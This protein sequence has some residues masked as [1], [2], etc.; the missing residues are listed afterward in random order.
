[1][2]R[3]S[4]NIKQSGT[5]N[6]VSR[7]G[8]LRGTTL[9]GLLVFGATGARARETA[10]ETTADVVLYNGR[11]TT[12][13]DGKP[14]VEAV[15]LRDGTVVAL[16]TSRELLAMGQHE[17]I[18]LG[19]ARVVP[20]LREVSSDAF[21]RGLTADREVSWAGVAS[22]VDGLYRL[23][24]RAAR[25]APG[26][27]MV[28]PGDWS[29][30]AVSAGRLPTGAELAKVAPQHPVAVFVH[31]RSV[32]MN[33]R[34][35]EALEIDEAFA[36]PPGTTVE[37]VSGRPTGRI[38]AYPS[39]TAIAGIRRRIA[40]QCRHTQSAAVT[41]SLQTLSRNGVVAVNAPVNAADLPVVEAVRSSG[42]GLP[43][44][45]TELL[46]RF[47]DA[48]RVAATVRMKGGG[49]DPVATAADFERFIEPSVFVPA[50]QER[51]LVASLTRALESG[52]AV[53]YEA[54]YDQG[55]K[56]FHTALQ[57]A[58]KA[59][60]VTDGTVQVIGAEM[61]AAETCRALR[62]SGCGV[63][64]RSSLATMG[65]DVAERH[66]TAAIPTHDARDING[67]SASCAGGENVAPWEALRY[68]TTCRTVA[69]RR[70][71]NAGLTREEALRL[72][73]APLQVGG[74]ADL[75]VLN[76]DVLRC[77]DEALAQT[78]ATLTIQGGRISYQRG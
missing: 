11:V 24:E 61:V 8:F 76:R 25:L 73:A 40:E 63:V 14:E 58:R 60:G 68:L 45:T 49:S 44:I 77:G 1:M 37:R 28:V 35:M 64:L 34:A 43:R 23:R 66:G 74:A 51:D 52:Q 70:V 38:E 53:T 36:T 29:P 31:G 2:R 13:D 78:E 46:C 62:E 33:P 41:S 7:R 20:G 50:G 57:Q 4:K 71:P 12:L 30:K 55:A 16:G 32:V 59:S 15:A 75:A 54:T 69:G 18:D 27:W 5:L 6:A 56:R 47:R 48:D 9:A 39:A 3:D 26:E 67:V 72:F 65:D 17:A 10:A 19:G 42:H 22:L 21:T